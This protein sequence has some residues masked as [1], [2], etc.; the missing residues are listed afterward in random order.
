MVCVGAAIF[1]WPNGLAGSSCSGGWSL[2]RWFVSGPPSLLDRTVSPPSLLSR[3]LRPDAFCRGAPLRS[4][5]PGSCLGAFQLPGGTGILA[6]PLCVPC[7]AGSGPA[8]FAWPKGLV[9][10]CATPSLC[11]LFSVDSRTFI[12]HYSMLCSIF[13]TFCFSSTKLAVISKMDGWSDF[14]L[15]SYSWITL[16]RSKWIAGFKMT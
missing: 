6:C 13:F 7:G 3:R 11:G 2:P 10:S 5:P 4:E 1:A 12:G 16:L 15:R 14:D 8:I 9:G